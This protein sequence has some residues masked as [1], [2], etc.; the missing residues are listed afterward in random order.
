MRRSALV[1]LCVGLGVSLCACG[2][3]E[4]EQPTC[5]SD[6]P[7]IL[8]AESVPTASLIPCVDALP[9]GWVFH[10]FQ[11]DDSRATFSL[12]QQDGDGLLEVDLLSACDVTGQGSVV[13]GFPQAQ[14]YRST[15]NGG[16]SVVWTSTFPGGCALARLTFPEPP[17]QTDVDRMERAISFIARDELQPA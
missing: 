9:P 6:S 12:E 17:A 5:R 7:T 8:M 16:A 14:R 10:S 4:N 11:A 3:S 1:A 15:A 13:E 2:A